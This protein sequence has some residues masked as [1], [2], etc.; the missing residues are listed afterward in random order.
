[1]SDNGNFA[2]GL[3]ADLDSISQIASSVVNLDLVVQELFESTD[4]EDFVGGGL[5]SVDDELLRDLG[6]LAL[7]SGF[8]H[9]K[10]IK[11][12]TLSLLIHIKFSFAVKRKNQ[13]SGSCG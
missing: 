9:H 2:I 7:T 13:Q 12:K 11:Q 4:V 3:S 10:K 6:L 8:L 1:M 5:R